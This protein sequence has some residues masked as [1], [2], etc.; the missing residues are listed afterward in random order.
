MRVFFNGRIVDQSKA[1]VSVFDRGFMYGDGIYET[2]LARNGKI[3]R[4][5]EHLKRFFLSAKGIGLK[6]PLSAD[7][8]KKAAEKVLEVNSLESARVKIMASRGQAS[9]GYFDKKRPKPTIVVSASFFKFWPRG[10]YER[11]VKVS[12]SKVRR[13]SIQSLNPAIKSCNCLNQI[14]AANAAAGSGAFEA[15][16][17]NVDGFVAEGTIS[18][19]FIVKNGMLLTPGLKSGILGGVTRS[20]VLELAVLNGMAARESMIRPSEIDDADE[21]FITSTTLEIVPV[22]KIG[23][24]KIG[25]GVPGPVT[26]RLGGLLKDLI[27][28]ETS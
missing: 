28:R 24:K 15:I 2:L 20:A 8:F 10:I 14:L 27:D 26:K 18:N 3:F 7:E 23:S 6:L 22:V 17:L 12:L 9:P 1:K 5:E 13:N 16:M 4:P 21:C 11:G 19:I 25:A